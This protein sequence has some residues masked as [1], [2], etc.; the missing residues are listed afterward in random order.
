MRFR[1]LSILIG[2]IGLI[3]F[4]TTLVNPNRASANSVKFTDVDR[5]SSHYDGI[6][7]LVNKGAVN[8]YPDRTFRGSNPLIRPHA[9]KLFVGALELEKLA[10][11]EVTSYFNDVKPTDNY[12]DYIATVGKEGIFQ[13]DNRNFMPEKRLTR[14]Q[15][16]TTLVRAFDLESKGRHVKINLD[17]VGISHKENVQILADLGF[18]TETDNFRPKDAI[19]RAQFA[20]FL[21]RIST[22]NVPLKIVT[23][24]YGYN[25]SAM[26][27][28]Q[29]AI[30]GTG[31][32][33]TDIA[34]TWYEASRKMV[35]YYS[36]PNNYNEDSIGFYQF[37]KL[38]GSVGLS[39]AE[40]NEILADGGILK[41]KGAAF[42]QASTTHNV[43]EM[44]LI[45]H[46]YLE[47]G[48]GTSELATGEHRVGLDEEGNAVM[49]T[50]ANKD[51]LT[52]IKQVYNLFG[53]G[54]ADRCPQTCGSVYAYN[55]G[56]FTVEAAIDGGAKF[57]AGNYFE[58]GQDTLYKMRWNPSTPPSKP[59]KHQYATDVAWA[60]KQ[61]NRMGAMLDE[62]YGKLPNVSMVYE[63]PQFNNTPS[64]STL[65]TGEAIFRIDTNHPHV[66]KKA[67]VTADDGA[68]LVN[69]RTVPTT[70]TAFGNTVIE[71]L[72][73]DT[74][75]II[76]AENTNWYKVKVGS[77]EGWISGTYLEIEGVEPASFIASMAESI[78]VNEEVSASQE[79]VIGETIEDGVALRGTPTETGTVLQE[80]PIGTEVEILEEQ[81]DWLKV[82]FANQEGWI[83]V[84]SI[85]INH[86]V[87]LK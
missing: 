19:T 52:D 43:N 79:K 3:V 13:G 11:S 60:V 21:Y 44:Y 23:T 69:F 20:T 61:T 10:S 46:S 71:K 53:I 84:E 37:L 27:D 16:A 57:I 74:E 33:K 4:G 15:M 87:E 80:L 47:T 54:A 28:K 76:L 75:V 5:G 50:D 2:F 42:L 12:A 29:M 45:A 32:P 7:W 77:K 9:A 55:A 58:V 39:E 59:E 48:R 36:N 78:E 68:S 63:I 66:G 56:W 40:L 24:P 18:T 49:V 65:P 1:R 26:V 30:T 62:L 38:S 86:V 64:K 73:L 82:D 70:S 34:A 41:N 22:G 31:R 72:P 17:N 85:T 81:N 6:Y 35:E 14:E 8:G 67:K 51:S 83:P 25:F